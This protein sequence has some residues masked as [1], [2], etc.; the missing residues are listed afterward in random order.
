MDVRHEFI[1]YTTLKKNT[2][3]KLHAIGFGNIFLQKTVRYYLPPGHGNKEKKP[4]EV[5]Q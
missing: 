3:Q 5:C 2:G 4:R 1:S